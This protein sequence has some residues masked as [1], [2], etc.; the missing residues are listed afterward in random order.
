MNVKRFYSLNFSIDLF[1][2][3][4]SYTTKAKQKYTGILQEFFYKHTWYNFIAFSFIGFHK[5][6][7]QTMLYKEYTFT[8]HTHMQ[9]VH[10]VWWWCVYVLCVCGGGKVLCL[11]ARKSRHMSPACCSILKQNKQF[12]PS[13]FVSLYVHLAFIFSHNVLF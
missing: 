6:F 5:K 12:I 1:L 2:Y 11:Y 13:F 10:G 7:L 3:I 8:I 4:F 9:M